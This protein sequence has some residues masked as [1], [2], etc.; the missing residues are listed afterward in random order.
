M[1]IYFY[2]LL[3]YNILTRSRNMADR[4]NGFENRIGTQVGNTKQA[5]TWWTVIRRRWTYYLSRL[6]YYS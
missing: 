5:A 1:M 2:L 6:H 4:S 3:Q